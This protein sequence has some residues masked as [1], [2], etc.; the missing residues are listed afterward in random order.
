MAKS[1]GANLAPEELRLSAQSPG[2]GSGQRF[3]FAP[4]DRLFPSVVFSR[5]RN[6]QISERN[7]RVL[8]TT[9]PFCM[10]TS[11][12]GCRRRYLVRVQGG[13][14]LTADLEKV[15]AL[16][17]QRAGKSRGFSQ[18]FNSLVPA[19]ERC[20][21]SRGESIGKD[22]LLKPVFTSRWIG[23]ANTGRQAG[24]GPTCRA[25]HLAPEDQRF[26]TISSHPQSVSTG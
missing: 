16:R 8:R 10:M 26:K 13:R 11:A 23:F 9:L 2:L 21:K 14:E 20:R 24:L 5:Q 25:S 1:A 12:R 15:A 7:L 3:R 4:V 17:R 19:N 22:H 6:C 18:N